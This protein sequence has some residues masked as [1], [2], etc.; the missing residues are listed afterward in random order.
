MKYIS[1]SNAE[2]VAEMVLEGKT[3]AQIK[4]DD[5]KRANTFK[6]LLYVG[7]WDELG[8]K[9]GAKVSRRTK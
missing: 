9:W 4:A 3:K 5:I 7:K 6:T 2:I 8:N 1:N